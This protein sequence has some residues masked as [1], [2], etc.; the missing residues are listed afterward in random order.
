MDAFSL[1]S[2]PSQST[3]V[4]RTTHLRAVFPMKTK[5][6][7]SKE[8]DFEKG[9]GQRGGNDNKTQRGSSSQHPAPNHKPTP[10]AC[11]LPAPPEPYQVLLVLPTALPPFTEVSAWCNPLATRSLSSPSLGWL[12]AAF[13]EGWGLKA[14]LEARRVFQVTSTGRALGQSS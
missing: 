12:P 8:M 6:P 11:P 5:S 9:P 1:G 2:S 10:S 3:R 7:L 14:V 13:G 4:S